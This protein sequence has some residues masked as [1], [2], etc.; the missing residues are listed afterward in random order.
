MFITYVQPDGT[1]DLVEADEGLSA[2]EVAVS[3]GV[4]GI[5]AD[6]GGSCNCATCHVFVAD[7]WIEK[8]G[9]PDPVEAALLAGR[10]DL[11]E[12]SRLACQIRLETELDG[13]VLHLPESQFL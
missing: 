5:E 6:C 4:S 11:A 13:L 8:V 2:M 7:E 9:P 12:N 10:S 3:H 1:S